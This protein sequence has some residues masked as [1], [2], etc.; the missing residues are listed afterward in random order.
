MGNSGKK[1]AEGGKKGVE[2]LMRGDKKE[3]VGGGV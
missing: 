2:R 3:V 1:G